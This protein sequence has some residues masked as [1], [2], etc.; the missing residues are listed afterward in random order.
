MHHKHTH[1]R[2]TGIRDAPL[3]CGTGSSCSAVAESC[4]CNSGWTS[5]NNGATTT[6]TTTCVDINECETGAAT[7]NNG[8]PCFNTQGSYFCSCD[9]ESVAALPGPGCTTNRTL[10]PWPCSGT[11]FDDCLSAAIPLS[12]SG[13]RLFD[14]TFPSIKISTN[15]CVLQSLLS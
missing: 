3:S 15:G 10:I 14:K 2:P 8:L 9:Y 4:T 13:F 5:A 11:S 7:C 12:G 6:T 1:A